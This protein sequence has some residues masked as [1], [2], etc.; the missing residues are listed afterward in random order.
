MELRAYIAQRR[1][2]LGLTQ[3]DIAKALG[4]SE[5]ALSKIESGA[6]LP[7]ISILPSLA[8]PLQLSLNDLLLMK[9]PE[10]FVSG[11]APYHGDSSSNSFSS[12]SATSG[13]AS[14]ST[15]PLTVVSSLPVAGLDE[16]VVVGSDGGSNE[17]AMKCPTAAAS[18]SHPPTWMR[19]RSISR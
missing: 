9:K 19:S 16:F 18:M 10:R 4:Y 3:T 7:P 8:D 5:T 1:K 2:D 15:D 14:T 17:E 13:G 11:S 12:N 6:S